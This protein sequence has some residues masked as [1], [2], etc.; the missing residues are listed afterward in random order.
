MPRESLSF[1]LFILI[2]MRV[3]IIAREEKVIRRTLDVKGD[4]MVQTK[5]ERAI[6]KKSDC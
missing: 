1:L 3:P 6:N 5:E 2:S 4:S